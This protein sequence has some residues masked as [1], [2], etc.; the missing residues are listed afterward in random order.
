MSV[1]SVESAAHELTEI[2]L[3]RMFQHKSS[4]NFH[5]ILFPFDIIPD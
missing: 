4:F 1:E 2:V 3:H 5:R